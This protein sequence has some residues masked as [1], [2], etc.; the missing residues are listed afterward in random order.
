[1]ENASVSDED[2]ALVYIRLVRKES[3][4]AA[5][6]IEQIYVH[7]GPRPA[8]RAALIITLLKHEIQQQS[9]PDTEMYTYLLQNFPEAFPWLEQAIT[10]CLQ[11]WGIPQIGKSGRGKGQPTQ[12][13][14]SDV[15]P[16]LF[17]DLLEQV[18][19]RNPI[20][21]VK[22]DQI[23]RNYGMTAG[24]YGATA[25]I[26]LQARTEKFGDG[27]QME[28]TDRDIREFPYFQSMGKNREALDHFT[29]MLDCYRIEQRPTSLSAFREAHFALKAEQSTERSEAIQ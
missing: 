12:E 22:L 5:T 13:T 28:L 20:T 16:S 18:R 24:G 6:V 26:W 10:C 1:M 9:L 19:Q 29:D 8:L 17:E 27:I 4:D 2:V 3:P 15:L 14:Q 21:A 7:F 11:A 25:L 23:Y